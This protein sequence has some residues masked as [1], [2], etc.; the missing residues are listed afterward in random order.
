MPGLAQAAPRHPWEVVELGRRD[1]ENWAVL[2]T[3]TRWEL[4]MLAG[5][6]DLI[7]SVWAALCC[8]GTKD[9]AA[10]LEERLLLPDCCLWG[11][12]GLF[13]LQ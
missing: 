1:W 10:F 8:G 12:P 9:Q 7:P 4:L 5:E 13:L 2:T 3:A 6:T 11:K